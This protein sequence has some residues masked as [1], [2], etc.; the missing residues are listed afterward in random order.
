V[1]LLLVPHV[2]I[3]RD[4]LVLITL[5]RKEGLLEHLLKI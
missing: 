4:L 5:L 1:Y 2:H 3:V